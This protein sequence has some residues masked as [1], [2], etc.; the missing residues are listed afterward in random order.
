MYNF[1]GDNLVNF[2]FIL[3]GITLGYQ[4]GYNKGVSY[5]FEKF[6]QLF[7]NLK[8]GGEQTDAGQN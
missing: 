6:N 3:I 8:K 4:T 7:S 2:L 5:A 1:V